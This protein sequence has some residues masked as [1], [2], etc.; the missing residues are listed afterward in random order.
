MYVHVY[1]QGN[2]S[3]SNDTQSITDNT[4]YGCAWVGVGFV[5]LI[6]RD[7]SSRLVTLCLSLRLEFFNNATVDLF[8]SLLYCQLGSFIVQQL[9]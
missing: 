7:I 3:A 6:T 8:Q 1:V 2:V 5:F 9:G 4:V